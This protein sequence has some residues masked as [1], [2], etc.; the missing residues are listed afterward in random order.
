MLDRLKHKS[1]IPKNDSLRRQPKYM[2]SDPL[3][4][5]VKAI[6]EGTHTFFLERERTRTLGRTP[7]SKGVG[8]TTPLRIH[9]KR[10]KRAAQPAHIDA[11]RTTR[12]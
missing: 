12:P 11:H 3:S 9:T 6:R 4:Q 7:N 2:T 1:K 5:V 10:V 8:Q